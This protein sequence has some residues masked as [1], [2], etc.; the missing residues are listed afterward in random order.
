[1]SRRRLYLAAIALS[2]VVVLDQVVKEIVRSSLDVGESLHVFGPLSIVHVANTGSVFGI[3]QGY[4][5]VPTIASIAILIAL[6]LVLRRAHARFGYVPTRPE[7]VFLGLVAGGAV[8]NLIDRLLLSGVTD[9]ID[10]QVMP[11]L[12]WPAFN[13]ADSCIV[14]GTLVLV[15]LLQRRGIFNA[16]ADSAG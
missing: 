16:T 14:V 12:H 5:I 8:G 6:P 9:F 4:V 1:M 13:L 15:F 11:G 10:V 3:G 7:A 2:A